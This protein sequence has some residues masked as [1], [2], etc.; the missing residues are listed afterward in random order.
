MDPRQI[1][2]EYRTLCQFDR[3][4]S[5]ST[6]TAV[7]PP[8]SNKNRYIN[9]EQP[10]KLRVIYSHQTALLQL[11][12][13]CVVTPSPGRPCAAPVVLPYDHNRVLLQQT[14]SDYI[15]A[16]HVGH[17]D[18]TGFSTSYIATQVRKGGRLVIGE[19]TRRGVRQRHCVSVPLP[20]P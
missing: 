10:L 9:G 14:K 7:E 1:A 16:S 11:S 8:N 5:A 13:S 12:L 17:A 3:M 18:A 20:V 19:D 2:D 15:N 4:I 6:S